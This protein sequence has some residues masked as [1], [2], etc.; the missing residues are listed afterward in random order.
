MDED[1]ILEILSKDPGHSSFVEYAEKL[2]MEGRNE[3][4]IITCIKGL[5]VNPNA[6]KGRLVLARALYQMNCVPFAVEQLKLLN[7]ALPEN[8][9]IKRLLDKLSPGSTAVSDAQAAE[10]TEAEAEFDFDD[11]DLLD[12]KD[13]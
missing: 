9:A 4:C 13:D 6:H 3:A 12:D 2:R 1:K 5:S 7:I 10:L 8:I 11:M